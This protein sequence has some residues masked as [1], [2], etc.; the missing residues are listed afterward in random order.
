MRALTFI[1]IALTLG[2]S[3]NFLILI[4]R[5]GMRMRELDPASGALC[6][7][8]SPH[9]EDEDEGGVSGATSPRHRALQ[10]SIIG[11]PAY[12]NVPAQRGENLS[13]CAGINVNRVVL[14]KTKFLSFKAEGF[15]E[16]LSMLINKLE[17]TAKHLLIMDNAP[18]H[19]SRN[20][21]NWF[22]INS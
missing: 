16:F 6:P 22:N 13:I 15:I 9:A 14:F 10:R 8:R 1:V 21:K 20:V 2:S 7:K 11:Q 17:P 5:T 19:H 4:P 12:V 18:I 3:P